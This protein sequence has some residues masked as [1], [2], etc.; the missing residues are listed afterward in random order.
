MS[1]KFSQPFKIQAVEKALNRSSDVTLKE[2]AN[3]LGV[4]H[5]TLGKWLIQSR[6]EVF[7]NPVKTT[8]TSMKEEKRPQ[9]W[10]PEER[11]NMIID[12]ASL[13][14]EKLNA[15]CRKMGVY[16]HH[17]EQWKQDFIGGSVGPSASQSSAQLK[18]LNKENKS[19]K[20]ELNRKEKALA[21]AAALLVLQKKVEGLC[22]KSDGGNS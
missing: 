16:T 12:C 21:E 8:M 3:S 11:L 13:R 1:R 6:K 10:T 5:S 19:L 7:N 2:I 17:I 18:S 22:W 4:G 20:T 9:D 14:G 15:H